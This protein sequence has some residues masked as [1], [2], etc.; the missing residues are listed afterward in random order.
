MMMMMIGFASFCF[1]GSACLDSRSEAITLETFSGDA[2][3]RSSFDGMSASLLAFNSV[4]LDHAS[5][6]TTLGDD[7][8][9]SIWDGFVNPS[10]LF[11]CFY[12]GHIGNY[13]SMG[14]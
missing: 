9:A 5:M 10:T 14:E 12:K 11:V 7:W 6:K 13:Y 8:K 1:K 4:C 3:Q 2:K